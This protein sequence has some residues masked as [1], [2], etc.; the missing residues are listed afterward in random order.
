MHQNRVGAAVGKGQIERV[1]DETRA[2]VHAAHQ[3]P[4]GAV[5][6]RHHP[7][8]VVGISPSHKRK[9]EDLARTAAVSILVIL[10]YD[11]GVGCNRLT[12]QD[13]RLRARCR[14]D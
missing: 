2:T 5:D 8:S 6:I 10:S 12:T 4:A 1:P 13:W 3:L 7:L 14:N 11:G 9:R